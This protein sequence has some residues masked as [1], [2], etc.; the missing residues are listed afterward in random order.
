MKQNNDFMRHKIKYQ[1]FNIIY[2]LLV[3]WA[4]MDTTVQRRERKTPVNRKIIIIMVLVFIL[5]IIAFSV[6]MLYNILTYDKVYKG[7]YVNDID[8]GSM[9]DNELESILNKRYQNKIDSSVLI[10]KGE[11]I[12]EKI[13]FSEMGL[14]YNISDAVRKAYKV[15]RTGNLFSK[16]LDISRLERHR[17]IINMSVTYDRSK[18]NK[19]VDRFSEKVN[20]VL[21]HPEAFVKNDMLILKEGQTGISVREEALLKAI[22]KVVVNPSEENTINLPVNRTLPRELDEDSIFESI[23]IEK[24]NAAFE[25]EGDS[26]KI[27]KHVNGV[28]IDKA[29]LASV[30]NELEKSEMEE[31]SIPLV[32][33]KPEITEEDLGALLFR[34][35]LYSSTTQFDTST[36]NNANRAENIKLATACINSKILMPGEV[37]SFNETV[38]RRTAERGFKT[39]HVYYAGKIV[40]GIGGGICQVSTTLFD[41]VLHSDLEI[42]E[43]ACHMFTVS[44]IPLGSDATVSWGAVDLKFRNNTNWPILIEGWVTD[45]NRVVF[46]L[47]GTNENKSKTVEIFS[48]IRKTLDYKTKYVDDPLLEKGKTIVK[49]SGITGYIVDTYK[50]I[51][52]NG[53]EVD[54]KKIYTSYYQP[55]NEVIQRGIEPEP[56]QQPEQEQQP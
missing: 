39:A 4:Q 43:R 29:E 10:I 52:Q 34:D 56:Q 14:S 40:D 9:P 16:L 36:P 41:A 21:K 30:L 46:T 51:K 2:L 37:F 8:V 54:R 32:Y 11:G 5:F 42:V 31:A 25:S 12:N 47:I 7:V 17:R 15:G 26:I 1:F 45:D 49:L 50:I 38:G 28:T 55:R 22:E 27:L 18:I 19:I 33:E 35:V 48:P 24:K 6:K 13:S 3:G 44:Y 53:M 23:H 20:T